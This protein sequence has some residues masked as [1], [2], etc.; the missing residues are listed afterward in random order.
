MSRTS[1]P[2]LLLSCSGHW[3]VSS[4]NPSVPL[5]SEAQ[6]AQATLCYKLHQT[7]SHAMM[8][9]N[10]NDFHRLS[11]NF[12]LEFKELNC[13]PTVLQP[14][15]LGQSTIQRI[16]PLKAFRLKKHVKNSK[17]IKK[18]MRKKM[19]K[20]KKHQQTSEHPGTILCK[21]GHQIFALLWSNDRCK[22]SSNPTA[23]PSKISKDQLNINPSE[24]IIASVFIL[25]CAL[26]K[27]PAV[28]VSYSLFMNSQNHIRLVL[29]PAMAIARWYWDPEPPL[30]TQR[31]WAD[32]I[33]SQFPK[34]Y[35]HAAWSA[36][37]PIAEEHS[38]APDIKK[39]RNRLI[40]QA[41]T[42]ATS[43]LR[44]QRSIRTEPEVQSCF[45]DATV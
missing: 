16:E 5:C 19:L 35:H 20:C 40:L 34:C 27:H 31:F 17:Y 21:C 28:T 32:Q 43:V 4:Q 25:S 11:L 45:Q 1:R 12:H 7:Y 8:T 2:A 10:V 33:W 9:T 39:L 23:S 42:D 36:N 6:A 24:Q 13:N 14:W 29:Q 44:F 15:N 38:T 37:V 18:H 41:L 26:Q 30:K 3:L 22:L